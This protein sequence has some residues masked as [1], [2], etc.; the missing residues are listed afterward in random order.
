M[1]IGGA[2]AGSSL[3]LAY[4]KDYAKARS[5]IHWISTE[6]LSITEGET[7]KREHKEG[8]GVRHALLPRNTRRVTLTEE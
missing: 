5:F 8:S 6:L 7:K 4:E 3:Q 1:L 2:S